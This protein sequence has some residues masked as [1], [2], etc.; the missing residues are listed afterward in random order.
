VGPHCPS[1]QTRLQIRLAS[2]QIKTRRDWCIFVT[3]TTSKNPVFADTFTKVHYTLTVDC[4]CLIGRSLLLLATGS[5]QLSQRRR[6]RYLIRSHLGVVLTVKPVA[7][8]PGTSRI[9]TYG[10]PVHGNSP[11]SLGS[12]GVDS[13]YVYRVGIGSSHVS[14]GGAVRIVRLSSIR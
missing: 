14:Q 3:V 2:T 11:I 7:T 12:N 10:C 6:T 9:S 8:I 13:F 1:S 4:K 5:S